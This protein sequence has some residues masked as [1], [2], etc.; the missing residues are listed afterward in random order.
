MWVASSMTDN[1]FKRAKIDL[2]SLSIFNLNIER[3]EFEKEIKEIPYPIDQSALNTQMP[4]STITSS[5]T[6][7]TDGDGVANLVDAFPLDPAEQIDTDGDGIGNNA[8]N[9]DDGDKYLDVTENTA[10]SNPLDKSS[11]PN[12]Y[13]RHSKYPYI[14]SIR[15][16]TIKLNSN[17]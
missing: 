9:D 8:D 1:V 13:V 3:K 15:N 6:E 10:G 5:P 12:Y 16:M 17:N 4:V 2:P 7:D 11:I 14:L